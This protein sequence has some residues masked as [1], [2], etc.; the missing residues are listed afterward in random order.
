MTNDESRSP[1]HLP[2]HAQD[3][4]TQTVGCRRGAPEHC[5]LH[6]GAGCSFA[7]A[8]GLCL[9]PPLSWKRQYEKLAA[10]RARSP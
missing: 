7:R 8:D 5:K 10:D 9:T 2:L 4:A 3:T 6:R 1:F